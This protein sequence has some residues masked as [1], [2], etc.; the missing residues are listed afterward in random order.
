MRLTR[1]STRVIAGVCAGIAE[2]FGWSR[3]AVRVSWVLLSVLSV[4]FPG[5]LAYTV[6]GMLMPPPAPGTGRE[7]HLDEYRVQ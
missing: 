7:F 1:S 2:Y 5:I 6:L 4:G 3:G